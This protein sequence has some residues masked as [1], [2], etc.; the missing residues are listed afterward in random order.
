MVC[1]SGST[2]GACAGF[3]AAVG[4]S[5]TSGARASRWGT[6]GR[7]KYLYLGAPDTACDVEACP[8]MFRA[9]ESYQV[10]SIRMSVNGGVLKLTAGGKGAIGP[11]GP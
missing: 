6:I 1:D 11:L 3:T 7:L 5:S 4:A 8:R 9:K 10:A 2:F